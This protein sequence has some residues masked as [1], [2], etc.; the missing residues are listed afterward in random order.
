MYDTIIIGAGSS[1]LMCAA[2]LV[3]DGM[4]NVLLLDSNPK[5]GKKLAITGNG[6]CNLTNLSLDKDLY[7]S[8]DKDRL[9]KV[10]SYFGVDETINFFE[11]E[12]GLKTVSKD[13]LVYPVTLKS[14]SVIDVLRFYISKID[15]EYELKVDKVS[16]DAEGYTVFAG[17]K[18]FE[19]RNVVFATGGMS[20]PKTGSDGN[21]YRLLSR[22]F[23][24]EEFT[25][26]TPSL[27]QLKTSDRDL[28]SLSGFRFNSRVS[29]I[30][31]DE[32]KATEVGELLFT[33]YGISGICVMQLSRHLTNGRNKVVID[34]LVDD[35][36]ICD[37]LRRFSH[38]SVPDALIGILPSELTKTVLKR[39]GT[40]ELKDPSVIRR[41]IRMLHEFTVNISGTNG[42]DNSQVTRGG[43][44]LNALDDE[45]QSREHKGL[46]VCGEVLNVDGPCGGYNLQWAWS[47]AVVVADSIKRSIG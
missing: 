24:K 37:S 4:D 39:L 46:Y 14:S 21:G 41:F 16:Q 19:G 36:A 20:Y 38:R 33:D 9:Y 47:S 25:A 2:R 18:S 45:L 11:K 35:E 10:L 29:L 17:E 31:D 5:A 3:C 32:T 27:V 8:D 23:N 6:R 43:L 30:S 12:L 1:G 15:I 44:N 34:L 28:K 7:F 42:F 22:F 40:S 13:E 26:V